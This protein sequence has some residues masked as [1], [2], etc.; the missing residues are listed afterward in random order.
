[1]FEYTKLISKEF[2]KQGK[3]FEMISIDPDGKESLLNEIKL[4]ESL[5]DDPQ[6]SDNAQKRLTHLVYKHMG[7]YVDYFDQDP[8]G[9]VNS[10]LHINRLLESPKLISKEF[11][12]QGKVSEMISVNPHCE[13]ALLNRVRGLESLLDDPEKSDSAQQELSELVNESI[14]AFAESLYENPEK[15]VLFLFNFYRQSQ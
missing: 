14:K 15:F 13:A 1:M 11:L 3:V 10:I 9:F 8:E 5:L 4:M 6:H 12:K 2:L 7:S